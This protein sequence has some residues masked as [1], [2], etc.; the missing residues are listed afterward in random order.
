MAF[1][2]EVEVCPADAAECPGRCCVRIDGSSSDSHRTDPIEGTEYMHG[3]T[4]Q[5]WNVSCTGSAIHEYV[6][7]TGQ[8]LTALADGGSDFDDGIFTA[9]A[10]QKIL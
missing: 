1:Q 9:L 8:Q 2:G 4:G 6:N 5:E 10:G 7:V 3:D